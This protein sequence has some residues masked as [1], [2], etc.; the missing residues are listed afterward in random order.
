MNA[1]LANFHKNILWPMQVD[2]HKDNTNMMKHSP[3]C[4]LYFAY[5]LLLDPL[6]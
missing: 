5:I 3:S 6:A 4:E 2:Y 1:Y